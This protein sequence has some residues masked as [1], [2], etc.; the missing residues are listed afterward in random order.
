MQSNPPDAQHAPGPDTVGVQPASVDPAAVYPLP[1][2]PPASPAVGA[3]LGE[4]APAPDALPE[5][6]FDG[7]T[8]PPPPPAPRP[9]WPVVVGAFLLGGL[10]FSVLT[11]VVILLFVPVARNVRQPV[12]SAAPRTAATP[13]LG[14]T[15]PA[16]AAQP[17][18][19]A[20]ARAATRV[21]GP[22][23]GELALEGGDSVAYKDTLV[24]VR[25]F[26]AEATFRNAYH[27]DD[28]Y[29][30]DYGFF[31]RENEFDRSYRLYITSDRE[32]ALKLIVSSS[33]GSTLPALSRLSMRSD[34]TATPDKVFVPVAGGTLAHLNVLEGSTNRVQLAVR[35][36]LGLFFVN[37]SYVASLDLSKKIVRG[38]ISIGSAFLL[39]NNNPDQVVH[40][41]DFSI[42]SLDP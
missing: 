4:Y 19:T 9:I 7:Y 17:T 11:A 31:F 27:A 34:P 42:W 26:V 13:W 36:G 5:S 1:I 10:V 23:T 40:Y 22:A 20:L 29:G 30:W 16:T 3:P 41:T 28:N 32:W 39:D 35:G 38:S 21:Y 33:A 15:L 24:N 37:D 25:D 6:T 8:I 12:I 18:A 14:A 2:Y